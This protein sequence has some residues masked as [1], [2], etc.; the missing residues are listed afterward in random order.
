MNNLN[1][2]SD[3]QKIIFV[4]G[5]NE[6]IDVSG[7]NDL[8][9][10]SSKYNFAM[11]VT[12][13]PNE[14]AYDN[15]GKPTDNGTGIS[16]IYPVTNLWFDGIR[17]T[18]FI[19]V[20]NKHNIINVNDHKLKLDFNYE[21][22]L[23][24]IYDV[25]RLTGLELVGYTYKGFDEQLHEVPID[26]AI[27]PIN[28]LDNKFTLRFKYE[29][30]E[31]TD[32][33]E[34]P[35]ALSYN[36]TNYLLKTTESIVEED[37]S[38]YDITYSIKQSTLDIFEGL[39]RVIF[40]SKY[41]NEI[42]TK[43]IPMVLYL[44]PLDYTIIFRNEHNKEYIIGKPYYTAYLDKDSLYTIKLNFTPNNIKC[45]N[46]LHRIYANATII[47][48]DEN[49]PDVITII[50]NNQP[51]LINSICEFGIQTS[52]KV[53]TNGFLHTKLSFDIYCN[54]NKYPNYLT[55]TIDIYLEGDKSDKYFYYG[56]KNIPNLNNFSIDTLIGDADLINNLFNDYIDKDI[57]ANDFYFYNSD[58]EYNINYNSN[59][60][61]YCIIPNNYKDK[62]KPRWNA[63]ITNDHG[64]T[65]E[66]L[67]C[68]EWFKSY[69]CTI[70]DT[71]FII[72]IR[73]EGGKF[74]GK[75]K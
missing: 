17:L 54:E 47:K 51:Q 64:I 27:P 65:Y 52:N 20:D 37:Q 59:D 69:T 1:S 38:L 9:E 46:Q 13:L 53:P 40:R 28:S 29:V 72:Y 42:S 30:G 41:S 63:Q 55:K 14:P 49:D 56:Y 2:I 22:G 5:L 33:S 74:Y 23:I 61:F 44:N 48:D 3:Y 50:S 58:D 43:E 57:N 31:D 73:E 34:I 75:L 7:K 25:N 15:E 71:E 11:F 68:T 45:D 18:R 60:H 70:N 62:V 66:Y 16:G 39:I 4:K 35:K 36:Y 10:L 6:H 67:S 19:G 26:N 24:G 8:E 12:S 32:I 21:T